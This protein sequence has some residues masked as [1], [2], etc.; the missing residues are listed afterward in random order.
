MKNYTY[1]VLSLAA[2]SVLFGTTLLAQTIDAPS[3]DSIPGPLPATPFVFPESKEIT[4]DNGLHVF[5][6]EDHS[7]PRVT[8]SLVMKTGD[9]YDP[10]GKEGVATIAADMLTKGTDKETAAEIAQKL[11]GVGAS[12]SAS[13]A[14]EQ[15]TLSG[16]ALKKHAALLFAALGDALTKSS[17]PVDEIEKLRQQYIA[18]VASEQS[19]GA[20]LA[21][22]LSRKVIY[23][24]DHPLAR[25]QSKASLTAITPEDVK[26]F[27]TTWHRPNIASIAVVGD[28]TVP[29]V[30]KLLST[31]LKGWTKADVPTVSIKPM[32]TEKAGVYFIPRPGSVQSAVVVCAPAPSVTS[33]E[34]PAANITLSYIGSGFGSL[35][36]KT[37]RETYSYTYSPFAY[38]TRGNR[39][40]RAAA[41]AEVRTSVTDSALT[42]ILKEINGLGHT[43]PD[44]VAFAQRMAY[45]VGQYR[46][47][48]EKA[49]NVASMLQ[50][51]WMC[52]MP[53]S[54]AAEATERLESVGEGQ[55]TDY[56][57][58]YLDM[59]KLRVVVVGDPSVR[60]KIEKFGPVYTYDLDYKPV[61]EEQLA[62][63]D[64]SVD[65]LVEAYVKGLGGA[66]NVA[67][68]KSVVQAGPATM[69]MQG[70]N[71]KGRIE[72]KVLVPSMEMTL[73]DLGVMKQ[74]QW[75]NGS[76]AW[77]SMNGGE[78][79]E[80]D[81]DETARIIQEASL[82][83]VLNWKSKGYQATILGKRGGQILV[84]AVTAKGQEVRYAFDASTYLLVQTEKDE[85]TPQGPITVIEKL[86]DYQAVNGVKFPTTVKVE[87]PLYNMEYK[88]KVE[89]NPSSLTEA[90]FT[91]AKK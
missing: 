24:M 16:A 85:A 39:Y 62:D 64:M 4:L 10:A 44:P 78:A 47:S 50:Q 9:A 90:D 43:G 21:A 13:S 18:N 72:R 14:G 66:N 55:V 40:N 89:V 48:Y 27:H 42:V 77:V 70:Q 73:L 71:F 67:A 68:V 52:D 6:I 20:N 15:T 51:A 35:L 38:V 23:G 76:Q 26:N 37:L 8:F 30:K 3:I 49:S 83:P 33:T 81:A 1:R 25:A 45:E 57:R 58:N 86:S 31:H 41:G 75:T 88:Y 5:V 32:A 60:E 46:L 28:I 17:Y 84:K 74:Q 36:F 91:P 59:F 80:A 2:A 12:L 63:A 7:L 61:A 65:E 53:V 56:A 19:R 79:T 87:T 82:F 29:E 69:T 11:D 22:G 34:W 54:W